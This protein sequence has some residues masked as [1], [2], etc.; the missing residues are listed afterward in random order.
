LGGENMHGVDLGLGRR[1]F[2]LPSAKEKK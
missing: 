1:K 2:H